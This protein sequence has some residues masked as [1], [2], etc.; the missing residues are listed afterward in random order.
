VHEN[1]T[2]LNEQGM[3]DYF[4]GPQ[5]GTTTIDGTEYPVYNVDQQR[6]WYPITPAQYST[7]GVA[8]ENNAWSWM[9]NA[10]FNINGNLFNVPW[11]NKPIG[12]AAV[13]EAYHNGYKLA[14]DPRGNT[15]SFGDPFQDY[16]TG[17]GSRNRYSFATEFRIPILSTLDIDI[18]GRADKYV[19]ASI[20]DLAKT[21]GFSLEW[22]PI[23]S[24]L[25]R[26]S[27][28]TNFK[29]PDMQA[30]YQT[31]SASTVG[32]YA[33]PLQCIQA[34]DFNCPATQH[35]TYFT[36]YQGGSPNLLPET[37]HGWTYGLVWD[38]PWVDG[39]TFMADYWHTGVSN[40]INY[41]DQGT[42]LADEAGC[43][44][45]LQLSGAPYTAHAQG[46]AYCN[47]AIADVIRDASGNITAIHTGPINESSLYV[48]GIDASLDYNWTTRNWGDFHL[49]INYT[50]NLSYKERVLPTDPLLNTRYQNVASRVT[51]ILNWNRGAWDASISGLRYGS[52][53]SNNFGGCEVLPNGIMPSAGDP[54]CTPY[55]GMI[56][57]WITWSGS[58]GYQFDKR[59]KMTLIVHNIFDRVGEIPYY[60][61]GFEFIP[62]Q[63]GDTYD[64]RE[65]FLQINYKID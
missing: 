57:P 3:F 42:L 7:F 34:K 6:F 61:G 47:L 8:G 13:L 62:T 53:R 39:L 37:G 55:Y 51:G 45:G 10:T 25:L 65:V 12:W 1:Y 11:D 22:R 2:G 63:Q 58:V 29:A 52:L 30:I 40:A 56:R 23:P 14:P 19:D 46:S 41:I 44:T 31:Q 50:D 16:N 33:D 64:G 59:V 5:L 60:A 35:S 49:S 20:A 27:Y 18:S 32:I 54:A 4:F 24:L 36:Q 48:S 17:G 28:G 9:Q 15:T 21:W 26:G 38:V 43:I